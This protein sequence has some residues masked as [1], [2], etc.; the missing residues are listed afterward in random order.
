MLVAIDIALLFIVGAIVYYVFFKIMGRK[1][2]P[3]KQ[4]DKIVVP[5]LGPESFFNHIKNS[6]P[7]GTGLIYDVRT[8]IYDSTDDLYT[9]WP[10]DLDGDFIVN[11]KIINP[12][13]DRVMKSVMLNERRFS[14][15]KA[16]NLIVDS[17]T[18]VLKHMEAQRL[19]GTT[20]IIS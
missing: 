2:R 15:E 16:G 9:P 5:S 14:K 18:V 7:R 4:A 10:L 13:T 12:I 19:A 8:E 6:L 1:K 11:V 20:E 3:D 17:V